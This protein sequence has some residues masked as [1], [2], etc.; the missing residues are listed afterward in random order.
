MY[1]KM[2]LIEVKGNYLTESNISLCP[3]YPVVYYQLIMISN[4]TVWL[5]PR[6]D[7]PVVTL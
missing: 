5:R 1:G 7:R 2:K 3:D 4:P 6:P